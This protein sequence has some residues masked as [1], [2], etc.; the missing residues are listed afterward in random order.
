MLA[1]LVAL[2]ITLQPTDARQ[3]S[4]DAQDR[5]FEDLSILARA[6]KIVSVAVRDAALAITSK[7]RTP[8][9]NKL[10]S[11]HTSTAKVRIQNQELLCW[12]CTWLP[13]AFRQDG[14]K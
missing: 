13:R 11:L 6:G 3:F 12:P 4:G 9:T 14:R 7:R 10:T 5:A 2:A 8:T 1:L